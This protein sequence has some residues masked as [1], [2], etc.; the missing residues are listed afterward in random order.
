M[1]LRIGESD[2]FSSFPFRSPADTFIR[3]PIDQSMTLCIHMP[4]MGPSSVRTM[5]LRGYAAIFSISVFSA[6]FTGN[7]LLVSA[8]VRQAPS[9]GP[10]YVA[11][12]GVTV[13]CPG[14]AV[15]DT[16]DINGVTYT[17]ENSSTL[18]SLAKNSSPQLT[19]SCTTGI[20]SMSKLFYY[21]TSFNVDISSWD[22]SSV[23]TMFEMFYVRASPSRVSLLLRRR[24]VV[25]GRPL[26][27]RSDITA[28]STRPPV[29]RCAVECLCLQSAHR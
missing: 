16:F 17:R 15:G 13:M 14:V 20:T 2:A 18:K 29:P 4:A 19:T 6:I 3:Q 21:K 11:P 12:N 22:T 10:Y 24:I 9:S 27:P 25:I 26:S 5:L 28:H 7:L 8:A 1:I 23:T